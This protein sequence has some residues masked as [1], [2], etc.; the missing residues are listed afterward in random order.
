MT[1]AL[2][3]KRA[4]C[5]LSD[6]IL[7]I[8]ARYPHVPCFQIRFPEA[9]K[10]PLREAEDGR[11][12]AEVEAAQLRVEVEASGG[13]GMTSSSAW[14]WLRRRCAASP[15]PSVPPSPPSRGW[16]RKGCRVSVAGVVVGVNDSWVC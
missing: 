3:D 1:F 4:P 14:G 11:Q 16:G 15:P 6:F 9:M 5:V 12:K 10:G 8:A 13:G 7:D 2:F